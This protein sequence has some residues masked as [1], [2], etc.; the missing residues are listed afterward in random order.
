MIDV[1]TIDWNEAWKKPEE[2]EKG[3]KVFISCAD[4]WSEKERC[5]RFNKTARENN[6]GASR[7]RIN[8]MNISPDSRVL[9]VGSGPGTLTIPLAGLVKEVTAVEPSAFM[10]ECLAANVAKDNLQNVVIVPKKW[11]NVDCSLD[12]HGPYDVVI[13]SYSLGFPDLREGLQKMDQISCGFVY[14][15]WFADMLSPWQKNY[16]DIWE[17]L[18]GIPFKKYQK[19]NIVFNL[20]HQMG[21][22]A[23]VEVTKEIHQQKFASLDEAVRDQGAGLNLETPQQ[24]TVLREYLEK[25]LLYQDG[26]YTMSSVSPRAMI[27]WKKD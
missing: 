20:L 2:G 27:W 25:K 5:D 19:P 24:Y 15:F 8:A 26:Q 12:L 21:I 14:I 16:G 1:T 22:Y 6:W 4:R 17:A 13:A 7:A 10:R 3:K 9:D 11:E 23:N 18:Y